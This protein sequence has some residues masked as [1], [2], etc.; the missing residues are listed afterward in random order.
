MV[1]DPDC[2]M[3]DA[4]DLAAD[5]RFVI[6]CNH[7]HYLI[8]TPAGYRSDGPSI[9]WFARGLISVTGRTWAAALPHDVGYGMEGFDDLIP[10][11]IWDSMFD[12]S[13]GKCDVPRIKRALM[14]QCVRLFGEAA[15]RKTSKINAY[16]RERGY[17]PRISRVSVTISHE[18]Y[19]HSSRP[20]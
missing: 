2:A 10:R 7:S 9:P 14:V 4:L 6:T 19:H 3:P 18:P 16:N 11:R 20:H 13:L 1:A 5:W 15:Y 17:L 8:E 12:L